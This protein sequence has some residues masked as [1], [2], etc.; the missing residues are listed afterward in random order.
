[1][2]NMTTLASHFD[3]AGGAIILAMIAFSVVFLVLAA[4]SLIIVA[5]RRI[6][7]K[8]ESFKKTAAPAPKKASSPK[9]AASQ[10]V[11]ASPSAPAQSAASGEDE[12]EIAAVITAAIAATLGSGAAILDIRPSMSMRMEGLD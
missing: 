7:E 6:A 1:M 4:L 12:S 11:A 9:G 8:V 3:G 5:N 2:E 10:K